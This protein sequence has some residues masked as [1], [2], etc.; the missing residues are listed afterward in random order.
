MR[1]TP[2]FEIIPNKKCPKQFRVIETAYFK[3]CIAAL[4]LKSKQI[5]YL[6]QCKCMFRQEG[7]L[8]GMA[9]NHP[10]NTQSQLSKKYKTDSKFQLFDFHLGKN[11]VIIYLVVEERAIVLL[12]T[13]GSH[14]TVFDHKGKLKIDIDSLVSDIVDQFISVVDNQSIQN[15]PKV[16]EAFAQKN[17]NNLVLIY[18]NGNKRICPMSKIIS[19]NS[20]YMP[21]ED[22]EFFKTARLD[23][24]FVKWDDGESEV[25]IAIGQI[26]GR[27]IDLKEFLDL[28][29]N[30]LQYSRSLKDRRLYNECVTLSKRRLCI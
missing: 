15:E 4:K 24:D 20:Y 14:K 12:I 29:R 13:A 6:D 27:S 11:I 18:D 2:L 19:K 16:I 22:T 21:L 28:L 25:K 17:S 7:T 30:T 1:Y 3:E 26:E 5:G 23:G 10:L 9:D 8:G